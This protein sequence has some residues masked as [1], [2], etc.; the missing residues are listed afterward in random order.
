MARRNDAGRRRRPTIWL[1]ALL[2]ALFAFAACLPA[3]ALA[4]D[5]LYLGGMHKVVVVDGDT[6]EVL[7]DIPIKGF[8]LYLVPDESKQRLYVVAGG[9]ELIHVIDLA[10]RKVIDTLSFSVPGQRQARVYG[11]VVD[12]AANRMYAVIQPSVFI[13][14]EDIGYEAPY[15]AVVDL[16]SKKTTARIK[17]PTG[18]SYLAWSGDRKTLYAIGHDLYHIDVPSLR[19]R[20]TTPIAH[21]PDPG[22]GGT[23]FI[24]EWFHPESSNGLGAI[25]YGTADP[26]TSLEQTGLLLLDVNTGNI[27]FLDIGPP[28]RISYHFSAV[29][30]PDRKWAYMVFNNLSVIDLERRKIVDIVD[31]LES[32]YAVNISSNGKKVYVAGGGASMSVVDAATRKILKRVILPADVWDFVVIPGAPSAGAVPGKK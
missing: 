12:A 1:R 13:G 17:V 11:L 15:V 9:R 29:V 18:V 10:E 31:V 20:E 7:G 3:P 30:S 8:P 5:L 22:R 25:V 14:M 6:D 19:I 4:K 23:V 21:P 16:A 2:G 28:P 26:A 32:H 24:A 27:D